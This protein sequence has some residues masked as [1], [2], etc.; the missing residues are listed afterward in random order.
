MKKIISLAIPLGVGFL[1]S[2]ATK[3][4]S[5]VYQSL[6]LPNFAPSGSVFPIMWTILYILMGVSSYL[7]YV[8]N[9]NTI[10]NSLKIYALSLVV[11]FLWSIIFFSINLYIVSFVWLL[12]LLALIIYMASL[13]YNEYKIAGILQIPYILWVI[14][15][16]ILNFSIILLN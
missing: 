1:G 16:G 12:I 3:N 4:A 14:F 8:K 2:L 5:E 7:I 9:G 13:F 6:S 15:A 10:S 11:N